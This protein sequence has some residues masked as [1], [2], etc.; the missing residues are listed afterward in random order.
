MHPER[1]VFSE[2]EVKL[3]E[4]FQTLIGKLGVQTL[5]LVW[6][7]DSD[8]SVSGEVRNGVVYVYEEE[9]G[10]A[11]E[12]LK[13]ELIDYLVTSRIVKPLV[14]LINLLIKSRESD[15]YREKETIIEALSKM[16]V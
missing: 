14:E 6:T 3:R 11:L 7:P 15:I 8:K 10:K 4:E 5:K 2:T 9:E 1:W 12:T 16:L 13:H